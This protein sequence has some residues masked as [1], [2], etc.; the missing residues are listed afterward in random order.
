M[1]ERVQA[2]AGDLLQPTEPPLAIPPGFDYAGVR[3]LSQ[4]VIVY[5]I[6][7]SLGV[8]FEIVVVENGSS[9]DTA[10]IAN[11]LAGEW[12]EVRSLSRPGR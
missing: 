3:G 8:P 9:D 7:A 1:G 10:A 6:A 4:M 11:R 5:I 2:V 12:P